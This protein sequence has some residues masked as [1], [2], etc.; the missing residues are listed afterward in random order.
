MDVDCL[1]LPRIT[2]S[3]PGILIDIT[4][5]KVP[6]NIQIADPQFYNEVSKFDYESN[7]KTLGLCWSLSPDCLMYKIKKDL[8]VNRV[9]K[10]TKFSIIA[11][12][13]IR[14]SYYTSKNYITEFVAR[15]AFL[16]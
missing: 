16:G 2:S 12:M 8:E 4:D 14:A 3:I 7:A 9:T 5:L 11:I 15:K 10:R 1:I 13:F 6:P